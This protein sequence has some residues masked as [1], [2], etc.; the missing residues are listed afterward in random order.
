MKRHIK[1]VIG[2]YKANGLKHTISALFSK[3]HKILKIRFRRGVFSYDAKKKI[4]E[5]E[6]NS[7]NNH[8]KTS[9]KMIVWLIFSFFRSYKSDK[10]VCKK[11]EN[12]DNDLPVEKLMLNKSKLNI[13][14]YLRGGLGDF[15]V[16]FNYI[17]AFWLKFKDEN[18]CIYVSAHVSENTAKTFYNMIFSNKNVEFISK[19]TTRA[20]ENKFDIYIDLLRYPDLKRIKNQVTVEKSLKI[21]EYCELLKKHRIEYERYYTRGA[22]FHGQSAQLGALKGIIRLQQP[23]V[24]GYFNL[25][26]DYIAPFKVDSFNILKNNNI[27]KKYITI[28]RGVDANHNDYS[29]KLWPI[30]YYEILIR[31]IKKEFPNICIVQLG[32]N[33]ERCPRMRGIDVSLVGKT[34]I[35]SLAYVL[36]ESAFHIDCEGGQV[37]LRKAIGGG[38]SIVLFGPTSPEFFGYKDNMNI[39]T[40]ACDMCCEWVTRNW[41]DKCI[42]G[43]KHAD[44]MY[45]I[46]PEKV[47]G[48]IQD[49]L[50]RISE[51]S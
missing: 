35:E 6:K 39:R 40:N 47:F 17:Y 31:I 30:D 34:S 32:V 24:Y 23:D 11:L 27:P 13:A 49:D 36:K 43:Y 20:Y 8:Y 25:P 21:F 16:A 15:L 50:R 22:D 5:F 44:C 26:Q 12:Q 2:Y 10:K 3:T 46:I 29:T 18:V 42:R 41:Q 48:Y 38:K 28:H 1:K 45:S 37:H 51:E 14:F 7:P 4:D 19:T 33:E 9:F